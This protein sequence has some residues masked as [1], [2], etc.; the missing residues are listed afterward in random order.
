M[1]WGW[2]GDQHD[3]TVIVSEL[4]TNA[5]NHGR[6]VDHTLN[7]RLATLE[8]GALLI[9]VSDPVAGFS[10]P[11]ERRGAD[12]QSECGRGLYVIQALGG[13]VSWFLCD[14]GGKTVRAHLPAP[15]SRARAGNAPQPTAAAVTGHNLGSASGRDVR[16]ART[17]TV[18]GP[19]YRGG[20]TH[21]A[22]VPRPHVPWGS[23]RS[24]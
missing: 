3:A 21:P 16:R 11:R 8:D 7:V 13:A 6:M 23:P 10:R 14:G 9:D 24:A 4:V 1:V 17:R 2:K 5:V 22:P 15:P 20:S 19:V 12:D 18:P